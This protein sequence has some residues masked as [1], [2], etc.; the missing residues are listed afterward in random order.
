MTLSQLW[1]FRRELFGNLELDKFPLLVKI[2]DAKDDLSIQVHPDD[3][4]AMQHEKGSLGKTE[5]WYILDCP[6]NATL[7]IGHNA[8]SR[9]ELTGMIS[10]GKWSQLIRE[11]PVHKGDFIQINPGTVHAIKAGMMIL[12]TQQNSDITYRVY[13]YDRLADGKPRKLHIK[14][15]IDVITVPA[16]PTEDCVKSAAHLPKNMMNELISC[17]YY[18]VWKLEVN[19]PVSFEQTHPFLIISVIE[20]EGLI[21]GQMIKKGDHFILPAGFGNMDMQGEMQLILSSVR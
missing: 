1:N 3:A 9:E 19:K 4:Y 18:I 17:S 7:I 10:Q 14:Q 21:N 20:G 11:V 2:I 13:D 12:E 8:E 5:C 16:A 15:S 6:E